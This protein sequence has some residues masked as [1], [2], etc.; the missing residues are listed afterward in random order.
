MKA[1]KMGAE[2]LF[3]MRSKY[4]EIAQFQTLSLLFNKKLPGKTPGSKTII[5]Y[6]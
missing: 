4:E 2:I 1:E 5:I 3:F 6:L